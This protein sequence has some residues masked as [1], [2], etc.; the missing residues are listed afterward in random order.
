[1]ISFTIKLLVQWHYNHLLL[2]PRKRTQSKIDEARCVMEQC[3]ME[4]EAV[5][6]RRSQLILKTL[7]QGKI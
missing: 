4:C 2:N 5:T 6:Y 3:C 7:M 1:L